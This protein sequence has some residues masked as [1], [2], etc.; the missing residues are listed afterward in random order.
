MSDLSLS[1]AIES[2]LVER[3]LR[4]MQLA[5]AALVPGY[6][7]RAAQHLRGIRGSV[8]IGTGF[9]VADTFETDGPIGAIALY[10]CLQAL[11]AQPLIACGPPL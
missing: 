1:Q 10:D 5:R 9:P 8:I 7:L 2:L 11:G 6:F 4:N 3:N